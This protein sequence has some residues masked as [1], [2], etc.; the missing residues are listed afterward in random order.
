MKKT[1]FTNCLI[2]DFLLKYFIV[3]NNVSILFEFN[4]RFYSIFNTFNIMNNKN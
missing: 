3:N 4:L 1:M 2:L